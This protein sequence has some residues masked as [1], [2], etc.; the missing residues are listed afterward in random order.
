MC[1]IGEAKLAKALI[2][3]AIKAAIFSGLFNAKRFGTN[4]PTIQDK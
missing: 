2:G 4:S 1:T 3:I